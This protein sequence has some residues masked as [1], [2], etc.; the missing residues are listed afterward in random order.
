[1]ASNRR[2]RWPFRCRGSRHESAVAQLF[3]LGS[4]KRMA[5]L[6]IILLF[7]LTVGCTSNKYTSVEGKFEV[8]LSATHS[9]DDSIGAKLVSISAD[10]TT[11]IQVIKS[12]RI[13][14]APVGGYFTSGGYGRIGL[15]LISASTEKHEARLLRRWGG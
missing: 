4:I 7:G 11:I 12:G 1:M 6:F 2:W 3:S 5:R 10:G 8:V 14:Q 15:Q 13:L 9:Q